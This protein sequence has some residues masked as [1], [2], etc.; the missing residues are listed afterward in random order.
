MQMNT[1]DR[2]TRPP[3]DHLALGTIVIV[4][5][6][7]TGAC[8]SAAAFLASGRRVRVLLEP[9]PFRSGSRSGI[10]HRLQAQG[11]PEVLAFTTETRDGSSAQAG[12]RV[13]HCIATLDPISSNALLFKKVDSAARGHFGVEVGAALRCSGAALALVAPAFPEAGRTV[14]SGI[15]KIRD[16][17]GQDA[18]IPLRSLFLDQNVSDLHVSDQLVS[19][20][21]VSDQLLSDQH[22]HRIGLLPASSEQHLERGIATALANGTRIL[23]CDSTSQQDLERLAAAALRVP[24]PLLWVGSAGL[25]HAL[26][27]TLPV[28]F[29]RA[30]PP[31]PAPET[32]RRHGRTLLFV[33]TPHPVTTLQVSHLEQNPAA[34]GRTIHRIQSDTTPE[35]DVV[36]AFLAAPV[37]A[38]ILTGGDTA[39]FVLR[40]LGATGISLAGELARG[41]PWGF[42][43]GGV[44]AGCVVVTKSGGFGRHDALLHA[45]EFCERRLV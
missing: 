10:E 7:L 21:H 16:C 35:Q 33:G 42:V 31:G 37:S 13:A 9:S 23:L 1:L 15:L 11:P 19:D 25:A 2:Q 41:I 20:L 29:P 17:S 40:S 38:L 32:R 18:A 6:D 4:A 12:Q 34:I 14:E 26:A 28:S 5:D 24:Q 43:E 36:A 3:H 30:T 8:D 44:A 39:S 45:F 27:A 22:A